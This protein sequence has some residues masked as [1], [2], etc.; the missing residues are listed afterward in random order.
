MRWLDGITDSIDL[1]L[2]KLWELV[3]DREAWG[4]QSMGSQRVGHDWMT[5]PN[6]ITLD[7]HEKMSWLCY[8]FVKSF[9][10][11]RSSS[12]CSLHGPRTQVLLPPQASFI[13]LG[14]LRQHSTEKPFINAQKEPAS[15]C[16]RQG[17]SSWVGKIPWRRKWQ[18]TPVFLPGKS[19][20]QR[21]LGA[22]VDGVAKNQTR[23]IN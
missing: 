13:T 19:H 8:G 14:F 22:T 11:Q 20:R 2:G 6:W 4:V 3:M 9:V 15:Q 21:G 16:S 1:S 10:S 5:K 7:G 18:P 17:F 23:V 12:V